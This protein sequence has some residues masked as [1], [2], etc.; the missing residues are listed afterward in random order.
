MMGNTAES[1]T[2]LIRQLY[3]S[4]GGDPDDLIITPNG[5]KSW[6]ISPEGYMVSR[7]STLEWTVISREHVD[8]LNNTCIQI[9]LRG[10]WSPAK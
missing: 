10:G 6:S 5:H 1:V 9:K 2:N 3:L 7:K 8:D 4:I